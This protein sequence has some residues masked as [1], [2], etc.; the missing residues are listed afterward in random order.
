MIE[1]RSIPRDSTAPRR[2]N[3]PNPSAAIT[4]VAIRFLAQAQ[5]PSDLLLGAA[6]GFRGCGFDLSEILVSSDPPSSE[7]DLRNFGRKS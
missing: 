4:A 1:S 6:S 3:F 7:H 2:Y 5:P